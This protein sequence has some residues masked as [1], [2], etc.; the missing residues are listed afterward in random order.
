M[1]CSVERNT[2]TTRFYNS[3]T[4]KFNI[5]FNGY[6]SFKTGVA[7]INNGH[8]DDYAEMLNV[9]EFSDPTVAPL[10]TADMDRAIQKASKL[11]S[12]KSIT[13]RPEIKNTRNISESDK[14]LL[15]RKEYN[16]WVDDSYLLIGKSRFYKREYS[17]AES[18][19]NYCITEAND[20]HIVT[21][22]YIWL[23]RIKAEEGD[24]SEARRLINEAG[25][26]ESNSSSLRFMYNTTLADI[27]IRQ[28]DYQDA[29]D[30]LAKAIKDA[31]GKRNR[32][33]LTYLLA[34]LYEQQGNS[35]MATA[36]YRKV[37]KMNPP[38]EVEFNARINMAGVFDIN[39]GNPA[40][41]RK[42]LEKMLRDSKNRDFRDQIYYA[43]AGLSMKEGN[44]A[45]ALEFYRKSAA[46][47][48]GNQN[49]RG[50][51]Y[52]SLADYYY[53]KADYKNAG[54]YLD[55]AV[56][57]I[58]QKHPRLPD[59][60]VR[61]QNLK[62]LITQLVVIEREDS[63]QRVA[64]LPPAE[65]NA[66]IAS[67]IQKVSK[68]GPQARNAEYTDRYNI[69]QY[70]ENEQRFQGNIEQEGKWYFYNQSALTFGRTE[71]RRRWGDRRLE[72]NW[73]RSNRTSTGVIHTVNDADSTA[74]Q[75]SPAD[76]AAAAAN[77]YTKPEY[78]L[79]DLPLTD[80]M[81]NLSNEKLSVAFLNAAKIYAEKIKDPG[82]ANE[83][84]EILLTRFPESPLVPE[85]LYE[86]YRNNSASNKT[87]AE[88]YRQRLL[89][90]YPESE[91]AKILSDP[92][93]YRNKMAD[94][95]VT[96]KL[97][98]E[99]YDLYQ[100]ERFEE[101]ITK[102]NT[103]L[104]QYPKNQLAPK[105]MLLHAYCIA[106]LTD[107][108]TFREDLKILIDTWPGTPESAKAS[109]LISNID[110]KVP[111]LK[112]EEEKKVAAQ[113]FTADTTG[114]K[115]FALVISDPTYNINQA[116][117]DVISYNI[118]YYTNN[119]YKTEGSLVDNKF[120]II[121]V[122]GFTNFSQAL[123]YYTRFQSAKP[124]RNPKGINM[125]AFVI[126]PENLAIL[127]SDKNPERYEIFFR[128]N[129]LK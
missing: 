112:V 19:F 58:D 95:E 39:T 31:P 54:L 99:S 2:A 129:L 72:D 4:A 12:L 59:L 80:S 40:E 122:S 93:Y 63:L 18:V 126:S 66:M 113:L 91:F 115:I 7:K 125:P 94:I 52:L 11:I 86:L 67:I 81:L 64:A 75:N 43:L 123:D 82:K 96:E 71:F 88:T 25:V 55:S 32:Y 108:R 1:Q 69:G 13:A 10:A 46:A 44:E 61:S 29:I 28:K 74:S 97:Y 114:S 120:I 90:K 9:F 107:E 119:N 34:Q 15:D 22:S 56:L 26:N 68:A 23:A 78:Y 53:D 92:D 57:F 73:R 49:Q 124:V 110:S 121:K 87:K 42:E 128:E 14:K 62:E 77:D 109:E 127:M 38:Y 16:D 103:A 84:Y 3:L 30:P 17:E 35:A 33:R 21:E 117:F 27:F 85:A 76:T 41:I 50:R 51:S 104:E 118:D 98:E 116:T 79:K 102:I 6:E 48:T 89:E 5:Y 8:H 111:Q 24:L 100:K 60:K 105:F 36:S 106:R 101:A 70:Y 83:T 37:A 47:S 20:P 45:E 65:R